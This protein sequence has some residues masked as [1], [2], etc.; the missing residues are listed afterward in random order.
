MDIITP[1]GRCIG[2]AAI[3]MF[4]ALMRTLAFAWLHIDC[5]EEEYTR[6]W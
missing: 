5:E 6:W 4:I 3:S 2:L 1:C